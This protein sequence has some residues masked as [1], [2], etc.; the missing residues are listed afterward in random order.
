MRKLIL[1]TFIIG[2]YSAFC[3]S[4]T[5]TKE[6]RK[7]KMEKLNKKLNK[8][9]EGPAG[10]FIKVDGEK[11]I[12]H[13]FPNTV[14]AFLDSSSDSDYL[15]STAK[16]HYYNEKG[17]LKKI[18]QAK[19]SE[20]YDGKNYYSRLK[21][22]SV[23]GLNRLHRIIITSDEYILT[24]YFSHGAFYYYLFDRKK[25][26]FVY[27]KIK[28]VVKSKKDNELADDYIR[29]YFTNCSK[30]ITRLNDNLSIE[31]KQ[32][33]NS[34]HFYSRMTAGMSNMKCE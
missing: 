18:S 14:K 32:K 12:M 33:L 19:I 1:L 10:Y 17:K 6:E 4:K 13:R 8:N 28:S 26:E 7:A 21:I 22:G 9:S 15:I 27:K 30:F 20:L 2:S 34:N 31:Y 29:P 5:L 11:V 16:V 25:E 23:F 24:E 3:Q